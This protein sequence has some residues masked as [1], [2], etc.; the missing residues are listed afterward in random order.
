MGQKGET[1][2]KVVRLSINMYYS[3]PSAFSAFPSLL[4]IAAIANF[5]GDDS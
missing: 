3:T 4:G 5:M 2:S 1:T